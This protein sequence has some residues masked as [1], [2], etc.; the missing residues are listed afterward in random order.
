MRSPRKYIPRI[1]G[2]RIQTEDNAKLM[3]E[4]RKKEEA[5]SSTSSM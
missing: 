3:I 4:E 1:F 5:K 2:F